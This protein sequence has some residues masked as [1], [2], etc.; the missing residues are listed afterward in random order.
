MATGSYNV[1][2]SKTTNFYQQLLF[3]IFLVF[4]LVMSYWLSCSFILHT[5]VHSGVCPTRIVNFLNAFNI[6]QPD[7]K[8]L[9][10]IYFISLCLSLFR[11][12]YNY[13]YHKKNNHENHVT[14]ISSGICQV[15][16]HMKLSVG[17]IDVC[18]YFKLFTFT[19][20]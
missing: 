11:Y 18:M 12:D 9:V 1:N 6:P 8:T 10:K 5:M 2:S 13:P 15:I 4:P 3:C 20:F 7:V 16:L 17:V 14:Y 19:L